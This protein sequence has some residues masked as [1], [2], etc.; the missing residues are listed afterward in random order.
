MNLNEFLCVTI[1]YALHLEEK[2]ISKIDKGLV[3]LR[4]KGQKNNVIAIILFSSFICFKSRQN[5]V[6][7]SGC[8]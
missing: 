5:T 1:G 8:P 2:L 3:K 4:V 6:S 7:H